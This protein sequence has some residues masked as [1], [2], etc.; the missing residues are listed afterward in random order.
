MPGYA[1]NFKVGN[2]VDIDLSPNFFD[3]IFFDPY[4]VHPDDIE[5]MVNKILRACK[6]GGKITF[7]TYSDVLKALRFIKIFRLKLVNWIGDLLPREIAKKLKRID[8]AE[9]SIGVYEQGGTKQSRCEISTTHAF[10]SKRK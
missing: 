9:V 10:M 8:H 6:P 5:H 2:I 3:F 1:E 4:D 7:Y